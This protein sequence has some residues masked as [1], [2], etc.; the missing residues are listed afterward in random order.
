MRMRVTHDEF[1]ARLER[2]RS[3]APLDLP[4]LV[5]V[6]EPVYYLTGSEPLRDAPAALVVERSTL[7]ALWPGS[8]PE[9]I[10]P[11]VESEVYALWPAGADAAAGSLA[12]GVRRLCPQGAV[13]DALDGRERFRLLMRRKTPAE[14]EVIEGNLRANDAAFGA[15]AAALRPGV[16]DYDL[17]AASLLA[18][19]R[20]ARGPV[21]WDGCVGLGVRGDYFDAQPG[22]AVGGDGDVAFVDLFPRRG[23]YAGDSTRSFAIG[24]APAWAERLHMVLVEALRAVER[25]LRPGASAAALDARCREILDGNDQNAVFP[26]HTGHGLGVFAQEAPFLVPGSTDTLAVGDVVAVEPGLYLP[27]VG[28]LRIEDAWE[29]TPDLPRRLNAFPRELTVCA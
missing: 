24:D 4:L 29:I 1:G 21:A 11:W 25:L 18:L 23:H 20:A 27:G 6:P 3:L 19:A 5:R 12:D 15:V 10:P 2:L 8:V 26:H 7:R 22:G 14:I 16:S 28:G 9:G 17:Y 13:D